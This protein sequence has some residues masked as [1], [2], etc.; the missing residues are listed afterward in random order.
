[1]KFP[2]ALESNRAGRT[3][4]VFEMDSDTLSFRKVFTIHWGVWEIHLPRIVRSS[5]DYWPELTLGQ[6]VVRLPTV[7]T[8]PC[9]MSPLSLSEWGMQV[10]ETSIGVGVGW[11]SSWVVYK[12]GRFQRRWS[13][14]IAKSIRECSVCCLSWH[15]NTGHWAPNPDEKWPLVHARFIH[16]QLPICEI[17]VHP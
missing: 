2:S 5:G 11:V 8:Q 16:C 6:Q 10:F 13:S 14:L 12:E 17:P 15:A 1:M 9:L 7:E 4:A 3:W